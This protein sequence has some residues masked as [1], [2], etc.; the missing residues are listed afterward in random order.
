MKGVDY[1]KMFSPVVMLSY[2]AINDVELNQ[3]NLKTAFVYGD[4]D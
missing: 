2:V 3:I 4:L 1:G